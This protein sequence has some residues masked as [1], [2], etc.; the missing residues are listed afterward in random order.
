MLHRTVWDASSTSSK[1]KLVSKLGKGVENV[2]SNCM[3]RVVRQFE[4]EVS[5]QTRKRGRKCYIELYGMR[6]PPVRKR[7]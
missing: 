3:G 6:R 7:S 4:K 2:T 1:K 5:H